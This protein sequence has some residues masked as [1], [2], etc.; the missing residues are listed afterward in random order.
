MIYL[1]GLALLSGLC[2]EPS[3]ATCPQLPLGAECYRNAS[4]LDTILWT[5]NTWEDNERLPLYPGFMDGIHRDRAVWGW[6]SIVQSVHHTDA[7]RES[8]QAS[9]IEAI[10]EA[11]FRNGWM[12]PVPKNWPETLPGGR[13]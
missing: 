2:G 8:A 4:R 9:I 13:R 1:F 7:E 6:A 11:A 12:P 10:G 3:S 5:L